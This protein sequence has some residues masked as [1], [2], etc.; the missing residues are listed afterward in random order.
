MSL[1]KDPEHLLLKKLVTLEAFLIQMGIY[2]LIWLWDDYMAT[3][4]SLILGGIALSL[5]LLTKMVEL[6]DQSNVPNVYYRLMFL[7]FLAPFIGA[8]LGILLRNGL[9]W[10]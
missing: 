7:S 4:L 9:S 3:V 6:I 8:I 5:Y 1:G 2:L 10:L